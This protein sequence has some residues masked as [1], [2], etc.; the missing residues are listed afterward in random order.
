MPGHGAKASI[1]IASEDFLTGALEAKDVELHGTVVN[2]SF[3]DKLSDFADRWWLVAVI[4]FGA[5][6]FLAV[7]PHKYIYHW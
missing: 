1:R 4:L 6:A 7:L 5:I 2:R 3:T